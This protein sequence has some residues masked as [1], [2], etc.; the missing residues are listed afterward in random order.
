M[1]SDYLEIDVYLEDDVTVDA[2][3]H[4][5]D[6]SL[7]PL[8]SLTTNIIR[9]H[10]VWTVEHKQLNQTVTAHFPAETVRY[11][12]T[13]RSGPPERFHYIG[14]DEPGDL[15]EYLHTSS[16]EFRDSE[17]ELNT[18]ENSDTTLYTH[19][20]E[21]CAGDA[22]T[23]HNRSDHSM[24]AF[25]QH[26]RGDRGIMERICEHGVG[27]PD[28]DDYRIYTGADAGVHGCDGCCG[29]ASNH[30]ETHPLEDLTEDLL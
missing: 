18:L 12:S 22:C 7:E 30:D 5:T 16:E 10:G 25:P 3:V 26:W 21:Q 23:I 14:D 2:Y 24:R 8:K 17:M 11:F 4:F 1:H 28:P 27:H 15:D 29:H 9:H 19:R 20:A 6:R 13:R